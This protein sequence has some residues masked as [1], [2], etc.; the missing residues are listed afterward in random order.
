M[1]DF[2]YHIIPELD[3]WMHPHH[4][5]PTDWFRLFVIISSLLVLM[6]YI[7]F[8]WQLIAM[9]ETL[10]KFVGKKFVITLALVF[11]FCGSCHAVHGLAYLH[12][13]VKLLHLLFYPVLLFFQFSLILLSMKAIS[14]LSK[15]KSIEYVEVITEENKRIKL[16][17]AQ[18]IE[19]VAKGV[20]A[21]DWTVIKDILK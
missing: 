7:F 4:C 17:Y 19:D 18:M 10:G 11:I 3:K 1:P 2:I 15:F 6:T 21:E 13:N 5:T 8:S 12:Q 14:T 20:I 9:R 16:K